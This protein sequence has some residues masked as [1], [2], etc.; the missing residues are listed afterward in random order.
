M[1]I[2]EDPMNMLPKLLEKIK[3][4]EDLARFYI[5]KSKLKILCKKMTQMK[6]EELAKIMK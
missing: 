4:F 3:Y 6:Q 2:T 1:L 5:N